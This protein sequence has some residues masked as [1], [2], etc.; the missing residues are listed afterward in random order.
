[1]CA[2]HSAP[3][4]LPGRFSYSAFSADLD[5]RPTRSLDEV[6]SLTPEQ[7]AP[8]SRLVSAAYNE[9]LQVAASL[10]EPGYRRL[11]TECLTAP[12]ITFLDLYP[13]EQDRKQIFAEMVRRGFFNPEDLVD[14][15]FAAQS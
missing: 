14:E 11:M 5:L 6:V 2:T 8:A 4:R 1:M 3:A 10:E 7:M 9:L 15:I 13:T 12:K